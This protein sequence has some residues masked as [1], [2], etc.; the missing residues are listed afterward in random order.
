[1]VRATREKAFDW[2]ATDS[3]VGEEIAR[4]YAELIWDGV[5]ADELPPGV[6]YFI[7]DCAQ[8]VNIDVALRWLRNVVGLSDTNKTAPLTDE[9]LAHVKEYDP[10]VLISG[11]EMLWRR[12]LKALADWYIDGRKQTN[13]V[14]RVKHRALKVIFETQNA[15]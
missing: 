1:M 2:A 10:E 13:H 7:F 4:S 12:R 3:L 9:E 5:T 14:N 11:V 8:S 15:D 6:D